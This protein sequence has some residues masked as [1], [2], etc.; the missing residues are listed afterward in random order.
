MASVSL[1]AD[2]LYAMIVKQSPPIALS[3][4]AKADAKRTA[5]QIWEGAAAD[6]RAWKLTE[7][8][9]VYN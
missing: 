9:A 5:E 3:E 4:E 2:Q 6:P 8:D 1:T 7:D